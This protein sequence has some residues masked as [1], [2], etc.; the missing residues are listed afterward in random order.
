[1]IFVS[2]LAPSS[3]ASTPVRARMS[4]AGQQGIQGKQ[5]EPQKKRGKGPTS[6]LLLAERLRLHSFNL[7]LCKDDVWRCQDVDVHVDVHV[8]VPL[9]G[10]ANKA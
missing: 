6:S 1:V 5:N 2:A 3:P 7:V 8:D 9:Q 4:E 10:G